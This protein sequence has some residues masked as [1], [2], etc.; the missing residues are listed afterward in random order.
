MQEGGRQAVIGTIKLLMVLH[1]TVRPA[2][3][4]GGGGRLQTRCL[5]MDHLLRFIVLLPNSCRNVTGIWRRIRNMGRSRRWRAYGGIR[6]G[7]AMLVNNF[8][9]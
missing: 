4:R 8:I 2:R 1:L 5:L 9:R 7:G 3:D 6:R